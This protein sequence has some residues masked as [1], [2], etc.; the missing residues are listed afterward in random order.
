MSL[1]VEKSMNGLTIADVAREA[2]CSVATASRVLSASKYPVSA[3]MQA[4]VL[5]AAAKLGYS[6]NLKKRMLVTD[7]NPF[8]GVIV[9][10]FQNPRYLLFIAGIEQMAKDERRQDAEMRANQPVRNPVFQT[11]GDDREQPLFLADHLE[12]IARSLLLSERVTRQT[13]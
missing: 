5:K 13:F 8:L 2:G 9:P 6:D 11:L 7:Q 1:E 12:P 4:R 3:S 10:T